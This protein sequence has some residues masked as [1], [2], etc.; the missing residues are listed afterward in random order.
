M[1]EYDFAQIE[2]KWQ[3][4]W[5]DRGAFHTTRVDGKPKYYCLVMFPYPSGELH[6]GHGRNYILGDALMRW[7]RKLGYNVMFPIGWDAFGLPAEN[8]ALE[9]NTSPRDWTESN[10]R[11]MT[12]QIKAWGAGFDWEREVTT[13]DPE[14]YKWTQLIFLW[15]HEKGLAYR[16]EASV[17]WCPKCSTVLANEQVIGGHCERCEAEVYLK[18]LEQW[19][20]RITDYAEELLRDA[21]VLEGWPERVRMMQA[22]WIGRSEGVDIYFKLDDGRDIPCFTTRQDTIFGATYAVV[23][24]DHPEIE[25][26]VKGTEEEAK[27]L[28][29]V[30]EFRATATQRKLEEVE[31]EGV[32]TGRFLINPV[33]EE[34]IPLWI[35]NYVVGEYGTGA[36]MAVPAHDQRDFEFARK[37]GLPIRMVIS[38]D[39]VAKDAASLEEAHVGPGVMV[40][41]AQF[42]GVDNEDGKAKVADWME[43][44]GI[45]KRCVR[46]KLRDWLIS[47]QRYWG[48][49]IPIVYCEKCGTVPVPETDLPVLLPELEEWKP[50]GE[51]PLKDLTAFVETTCPSC[52]GPGRRET[53]T[54]DTFV[55]STWYYLRYLNPADADIP[56]NPDEAAYWVPVDMY[57]GGIEHAIL[58]LLYSR[59][60]ARVFADVGYLK[61]REPFANLF[62]QGM[63]CKNGVK[64]SKSKGNAMP[65]DDLIERFGTDTVRLYTLFVGPP[66]KDVDWIDRGVEGCSR[67]INRLWRIVVMVSGFDEAGGV[68]SAGELNEEEL[69]L[70]R[71]AHWAIKKVKDDIENRFHFNTAISAVMELVNDMYRLLS[72]RDADALPDTSKRVLRFAAEAGVQMISAMTPH[73][74]EEMWQKLGHS[75][76][77]LYTPFPEHDESLLKTDTVSVVVQVNGKLRAN[78]DVPAGA[79]KEDVER[80]AREHES[81][82][83]WLEGK[84]VRRAVYVKDKLINFVVS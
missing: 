57:I 23:S 42:D 36:I 25:S 26:I 48:T 65:A 14:Y 81:V 29:F 70:L 17:N 50:T 38:P 58:H 69:A 77:L 59:F 56:W 18:R 47:R 46:Y 44:K 67:F 24:P 68:P 64:M 45:G 12:A 49:P 15:M 5:Q 83:K 80:T 53:D 34:R 19:F 72:D 51:S 40:N 52:G 32:P 8:A 28:E 55:D 31:K 41:S 84:T 39:G 7:K 1:E 79:S 9:H 22:N 3:K 10:I 75:T 37:Y 2:A 82:A 6:V 30:R 27:A 76:T 62:T 74:C 35:A 33:N 21:E 20:F 54:M 11:R 61:T 71:K 78:I 13:C 16:K 73:V 4:Y 60:V 43:E 63:I 66:E